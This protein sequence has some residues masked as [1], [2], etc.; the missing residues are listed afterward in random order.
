MAT[1]SILKD[2]DIKS[3]RLGENF[4]RALEQTIEQKPKEVLYSR[5]VTN[6]Q[7]DKI[8]DFFGEK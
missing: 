2:V 1:R 8:R 6:L 3:K 7:K 4:V 5:T